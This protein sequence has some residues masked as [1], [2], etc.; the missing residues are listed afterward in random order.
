MGTIN[1]FKPFLL[2]SNYS[3]LFDGDYYRMRN[4]PNTYIPTFILITTPIYI[5]FFFFI[6]FIYK[7][8]RFFIRLINVKEKSP[9]NDFWRGNNEKFDFFILI[10]FFLTFSFIVLMSF[11]VAHGW[12]HFYFLHFFI[13]YFL[14]FFFYI[15]NFF[16]KKYIFYFQIIIFFFCLD[17][18]IQNIK[19][20]P[21]QSLYF[22]KLVDDIENKFTVD[23]ISLSRSHALLKILKNSNK[24]VISVGTAAWSPLN[25]ADDFL[26]KNFRNKI[27]FVG[28]DFKRADFIYSINN[29][30]VNAKINKKYDIPLNFTL[31]YEKKVN[32][33][34]IYKIYKK[35]RK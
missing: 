2:S 9:Y 6:G 21:F 10:S 1:W 26:E 7:F 30:E 27:T 3:V 17:L 16:L 11:P 25:N 29:Y 19:F 31:F 8:K 14:I 28:Q 23:S 5:T 15:I 22:N 4:L 24:K 33:L 32:D 12:R 18:I 34:V 13:I 20:H 35:P